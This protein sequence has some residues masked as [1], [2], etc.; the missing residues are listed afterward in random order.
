MTVDLEMLTWTAVLCVVLFLPYV[1]CR[2][3]VWGLVATVGYPKNPPPLPDWAQRAQRAH[4]NLVENIGPFTA[5]VVVAHAGGAANEVTALGATIFFW[6]RL[7]QAVV[8]ILGVPWVRTL[9]FFVSLAGEVMI[10]RQILAA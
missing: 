9:A 8:H 5:L 1:L 7:V 3:S 6:A 4:L 10:L 2:I